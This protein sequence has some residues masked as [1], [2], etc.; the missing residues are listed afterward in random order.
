MRRINVFASVALSA[1][2]SAVCLQSF[3]VGADAPQATSSPAAPI[4]RVTAAFG[5]A[6][7]ESGK[8]ARPGDL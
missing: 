8:E 3:S 4:G 6:R 1:A 2:V 7:I 5:V